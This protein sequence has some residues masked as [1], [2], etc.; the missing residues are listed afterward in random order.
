MPLFQSPP[1]TP[2]EIEAS[3][4]L[5]IGPEEVLTLNE[6]EW[7]ARV[8]RGDSA[9]QL[10][11]RAVAMGCVLGFFLSFTNIY[12]GLKTGLY[13]GVA[14]TAVVLSFSI[15][16]T[17][18]RLG[19]AKSPMSILENN[20][21]QSCASSAGY[22]TG[23]I[24]LTAIPALLLLSVT[25][26]DPRG[27]NLPVWVV[28]TW[29]LLLSILGVALAIPMKRAM[30]NRER[31]RFPEGIA[32]AVTLQSLYSEGRDALL[33]A[34]ALY[35]SAT[36]GAL[37]PLTTALGL[38][39]SS[40]PRGAREPLLPDSSA[41]FDWLPGIRGGGRSYPP[42]A[43]TMRFDHSFLLI[44]AGVIVGLRVSA[45]L[46]LGGL[47]LA[48]F[49]G[50]HAMETTWLDPAGDLVAAVTKPGAAWKQIGLWYGAPLMVA[51]GLA[52]FLSQGKMIA[53]AVHVHAS[54]AQAPARATPT[55]PSCAAWRCRG[56]GSSWRRPWRGSRSSGSRGATSGSLRSWR[57]SPCSSRSSS[58]SSPRG[59]RGR[60]A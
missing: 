25:P 59:R 5:A 24:I 40:V 13:L 53:R 43:W 50:P 21:M 35:A 3:R 11:M 17:L 28:G 60:R 44:G 2:E 15:W 39:R 16:T 38:V 34:R 26:T 33:K 6:K 8:Y 31:L 46:V 20:C 18:E 1:R 14:I 36:L 19:V 32:A 55:T 42:S 48:L 30:I 12:I 54:S 10:T 57:R 51:Y 56:R 45:S 52:T 58:R 22:G 49:L 41:V 9:P 47:I 27:T 37:V 7:Y 29:T 4:P 23:S